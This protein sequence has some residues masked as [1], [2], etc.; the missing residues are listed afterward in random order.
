MG[1]TYLIL[2]VGL[3]S[4]AEPTVAVI[5]NGDFE[6]WTTARPGS[7]GLVSGWRLDDP[8]QIPVG[9]S[10]NS[11]YT[12]QLH[13]GKEGPLGPHSGQHFVRIVAADNGAHLYQMCKGLQAGVWYRVSAWTRGG[14]VTLCCY[15]YGK[16]KFLGSS[17]VAQ[18]TVSSEAWRLTTGYYRPP[19]GE[20]KASALAVCVAPGH[21]A[22]VDDVSMEPIAGVD[23]PASA[24]DMILETETTRLCLSPSGIV[25]QFR[26]KA[27]GED[28]SAG[29]SPLPVLSVVRKG[30]VV[31]LHHI[32]CN[33]ALLQ[34]QFLDSDV[35]ATLRV[36]TGKKHLLFEVVQVQP[37]DVE[38]FR[39]EVPLRRLKTVA[40]AFN[41]TYDE[42]F[43][44]CLF[45]AT[46]NVFNRPVSHGSDVF[47]PRVT[48]TNKHGLTGARFALVAASAHDFQAAIMEAEQASGLP[49]PMLEGRWARDSVSV[50][51][52]YL[53]VV[54]ATE[55]NIDRTIEYAKL[56]HFGMIIFL[57]DNWLS[58]HGHYTINTRN[59]PDGLESLKRVVAKIHAAGMGA[60][61]HVFGPSI[62]PNDPYVTPLPDER[63][64]SVVC[65]PLTEAVDAK[66]ATLTLASQ[67]NLPPKAPRSA[68]F[69]GFHLRVGDEIIRYGDVEAGPPFRFLKCQR[70]ALGTKPEPHPAG[71]S[72]RGLLTLWGYFL[73]DPDSTLAD[74]LVRNFGQMM[75]ACDFDM[76]YF[77]ASDG[78][79]DAYL[80]RWYYLNK[81]HLGFYRQFRKDMLYQTSNGTGTD[82]CWHLIPR[83]ASADGHGNIKGYLDQRWP[84]ILGMEANLTRPDV[85]WYYMYTDVRPDQIEYV[86]AKVLG[87]DGSISIETS[88]AAMEKHTYGRRM[89]EMLGRYEEC[90]LAGHF[91]AAVRSRLREPGKDFRL[92][93]EGSRWKLYRAIYEP[94]RVVEH[95]DG[96]NNVW[97]IRN[98]EAQPCSVAVEITRGARTI[99]SADYDGPQTLTIETFDDAGPYQPEETLS[100]ALRESVGARQTFAVSSPGAKVGPRW[101]VWKVK[102][103]GDHGG[104][105][106]VRRRF[107]QPLDLHAY[108]A[109]GMWV[110]GDGEGAT[111]RIQLR[112]TSGRL[113]TWLVPV[114]FHGWRLCTYAITGTGALDWSKIDTLLF[115]VQGLPVGVSAEVGLDDLKALTEIHTTGPLVSPALE[116]NGRR[117]PLSVNLAAGQGLTVDQL[118]GAHF[119]PGG[120]EPS[121]PLG[122]ERTAL[123]LKPGEN[124]IT[125][126][127]ETTGG[128]PGDISVIVS[129]LR[130][131]QE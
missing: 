71:T 4:A 25:R 82:L 11:I 83:S 118:G 108:K 9:W 22:D 39:M 17:S 24:A 123:V 106:S 101:A 119:W 63:L 130:P 80:D 91:P 73:V 56:G 120:M 66:A 68:A 79:N 6:T 94:P 60:G 41:A 103:G 28:Y 86:C 89:V 87:I 20:Y 70:G 44:M 58:T 10:L 121:Q 67:P 23:T 18:S 104:W 34:A 59:F 33:G 57:K 53:F 35:K 112:D 74:D 61:V 85:G 15:E 102:N 93:Q 65:P 49:C 5:T 111:L 1:L 124:R 105:A 100:P 54:D 110:R 50:R 64:A 42:R 14:P 26:S 38:E 30:V 127:A 75:N 122:I 97:T 46:V 32:T 129:R 55:A 29:L 51:R 16:S 21:P 27:T 99:P 113:A 77:D 98:D 72:V 125:F 126:A 36:S 131:L 8:P 117:L 43:G 96:K 19:A 52:S 12:G 76:V 116:I 37:A 81:L 69:P 78:I 88:Q 62:S 31:P 92:F 95:L 109:L 115:Y 45:G 13:V 2:T 7:N 114:G 128:Y 48:C 90:R 47:A 107:A 3:L 40:G 84:G